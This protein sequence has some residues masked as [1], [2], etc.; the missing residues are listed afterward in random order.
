MDPALRTRLV[1]AIA[2]GIQLGAVACAKR[3]PEPTRS[4]IASAVSTASAPD[5]AG[6]SSDA[7][8]DASN[9]SDIDAS[10]ASM[11]L[12]G[13][14]P[15]SGSHKMPNLACGAIARHPNGG[16]RGEVSIDGASSGAGPIAVGNRGMTQLRARMRIC[17]DKALELNPSE[18]GSVVL[19]IDVGADGS[20]TAAY[21]T[22]SSGLPASTNKCLV[23]MAQGSAFDGVGA[24]TKLKIGVSF[25]TGQ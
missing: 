5:S 19:A 22:S 1:A 16:F 15:L 17:Y 23:G 10:L 2:T 21:I 11:G 7:A 18:A 14:G 13:G 24:P 4:D 25:R 12:A 3:E 20:A 9:P 6:A 8:T